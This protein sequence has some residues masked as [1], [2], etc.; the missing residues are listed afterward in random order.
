MSTTATSA[1]ARSRASQDKPEEAARSRVGSFG[2]PKLKLDVPGVIP[3]YHLYWAN[4]SLDGAIEQLLNEGFEFVSPDEVGMQSFRRER[5][6]T[7]EDTVN[8]VSRF[9]GYNPDGGAQRAYLLKLPEDMWAERQAVGERMADERDSA[10][11]RQ[12]AGEDDGRYVPK[13]TR[14]SIDTKFRKEY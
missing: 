11:R 1:Q 9:V 14:S 7:D 12:A 8:R 2:G 5:T 4:D 3:G 13:D 6:V 10:I